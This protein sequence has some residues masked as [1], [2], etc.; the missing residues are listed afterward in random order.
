M[1]GYKLISVLTHQWILYQLRH[2]GSP[3]K[4]VEKLK[5]DPITDTIQ[6]VSVSH[7]SFKA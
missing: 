4:F 6:R 7:N 5:W 2:Q 1:G 3:S